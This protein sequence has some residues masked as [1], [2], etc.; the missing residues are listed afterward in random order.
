MF[1]V[2]T[3][4]VGELSDFDVSVHGR[5]LDPPRQQPQDQVRSIKIGEAD[6]QG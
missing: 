6:I 4:F 1:E 3:R 5:D 2:G